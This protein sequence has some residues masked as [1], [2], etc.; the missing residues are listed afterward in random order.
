[1]PEPSAHNS[2]NSHSPS[3]REVFIAPPATASISLREIFAAVA[4]RRWLFFSIV[5]GLLLACLLYCLIA[6]NQYEARASVELH[7]GANTTLGIE[8]PE[9]ASSTSILSAPLQLETLANVFRSER[10]AWKVIQELK[11]YQAPGFKGSFESRFPGFRPDAPGPNPSGP[12]ALNPEAQDWL[13]ERFKNQLHVQTLTRTLLIQIRF[14]SRDPGLSASVVNALIRAYVQQEQESRVQATAD[15][16]GW[17]SVQLKALK[18]R[19]DQDRNR[20][21]DFE[22]EHKILSSPETLSNG[23]ES[24]TQH[25]SVLLEIDELGRQLIAATTE[26]ILREAEYRAASQGNPELVF[27]SNPRPAGRGRQLCHGI[28]GAAPHAA[29]RARAGAGATQPGAW[30]QLSPRR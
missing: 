21:A 14:R 23:A 2:G 24:D 11:L 20:L 28:A 17:L 22:S 6:S 26:R 8:T 29:Q 12:D 5:G 25:N 10:L 18:D 15:A 1:M 4:R 7:T 19:V 3:I 13:L 16:T 9:P 30:S 27:A